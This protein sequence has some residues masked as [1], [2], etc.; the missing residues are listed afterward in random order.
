MSRPKWALPVFLIAVCGRGEKS[1]AGESSNSLAG[2]SP[3]TASGTG[4]AVTGAVV[5]RIE[6]G[7]INLRWEQFKDWI[8]RRDVAEGRGW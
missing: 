3:K 4:F 2:N 1:Q 7:E 8:V 5:S 6:G